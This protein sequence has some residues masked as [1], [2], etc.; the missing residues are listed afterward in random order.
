MTESMGQL[1]VV[2]ATKWPEKGAPGSRRGPGGVFRG[3]QGTE[4][5]QVTTTLTEGRSQEVSGEA[6]APEGPRPEVDR[7]TFQQL[8]RLAGVTEGGTRTSSEGGSEKALGGRVRAG[9]AERLGEIEPP[10][11]RTGS[12]GGGVGLVS[13]APPAGQGS[14]C[15]AR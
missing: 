3:W 5:A 2:L 12:K 7:L 1:Q 10:L 13:W 15:V 9:Q 6:G 14:G 4:G 11:G 8:T